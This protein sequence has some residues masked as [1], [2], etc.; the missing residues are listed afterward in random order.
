MSILTTSQL[1]FC[2]LKD[3]YSI[4]LD[5]ECIGVACDNNGAALEEKTVTIGYRGLMG[6][7]R[8][9]LTCEVSYLP[10]GIS[11][12]STTPSS[13]D[14]DGSIVLKI[15]Q[16]ADF[17]A[18][19]YASAKILFSTSN[20]LP[21]DNFTFEKYITLVKYM[22]GE[23]GTDAIAFKIYSNQGFVFKEDT[24]KIDLK[25]IALEGFEE[26]SGATYI[27][28]WFDPSQNKYIPIEGAS[29]QTL[30]V[31]RSDPY[32]LSSIECTMVLSD[33]K[34]YKDYVLLTN[35][36]VIY[37]PAV[38]FFGGSNIFTAND[39]FLVFCV[40][41]YQNNEKV[42]GVSTDK[43]YTKLVNV[44]DDNTIV[45]V[46]ETEDFKIDD[47]MYIVYE[48]Q[49]TD[50]TIYKVVLGKCSAVEQLAVEPIAENE[51]ESEIKIMFTWDVIEES[52]TYEYKNSIYPSILSNVIAVSK[53]DI[54]RS[55]NID[56][57]IFKNNVKVSNTSVMIID[58]NDPVV[59]D[60]APSNP[61]FGQMWLDTSTSPY[62]LMIFDKDDEGNGEWKKFSQ[63][64]GGTVHTSKPTSY[65]TGDL[66]ILNSG[67]KCGDFIEGAML[68]A[69][70]SSSVFSELHWEDAVKDLTDLKENVAQYFEFNKDSGLKIGQIDNKFYVNID[71][72]KM[73]FHSVSVDENNNTNDVE[74]VHIG[75]N[76][77]VIQNATF[78]GDQGTKFEN[79]TSFGGMISVH[80]TGSST[81]GFV[82][83]IEENGSFSLTVRSDLIETKE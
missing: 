45:T 46:S 69:I 23:S 22:V 48:H 3:S 67:E 13:K 56:I 41:L 11:L 57:E 63:Q 68:R 44:A 31:K 38:K 36:T 81:D 25:V 21:S 42:E 76:S 17:D 66:W 52:L 43:Y 15:A 9:G 16:G 33:G 60:V 51:T 29:E 32:A 61:I 26:I 62:T 10:T 47:K 53:N 79:N 2:D 58:S 14:S 72:Q 7:D 5:T 39:S 75:N 27:W 70:T 77:S 73:G 34:E 65:T 19:S 20:N 49:E 8:A 50:E 54:Y 83:L 12:I 71:S 64:N 35:E 59:G 78:Q 30:A 1:T 80:K 4:H 40:E 74:V 55:A 28:S 24:N 6:D 18:A 37:T 82:V